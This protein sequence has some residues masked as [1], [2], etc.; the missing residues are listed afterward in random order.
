MRTSIV[1]CLLGALGALFG[2]WLVARWCLGL[3]VIAESG[4]LIFWAVQ[5]DDGQ[6]PAVPAVPGQ[7]HTLA[8]V[9]E[10]AR[11]S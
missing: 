8:E 3:V 4:L 11:A 5:R 2:G 1:A 10:R 6:A 9:L 7:G